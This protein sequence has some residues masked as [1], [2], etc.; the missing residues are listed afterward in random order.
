MVRVRGEAPSRGRTVKPGEVQDLFRSGVDAVVQITESFE[1]PDWDKPVCGRWSAQ[2]TAQHVLA[3]AGWYHQWLDRAVAD[4]LDPPFLAAE[5]AEQNEVALSQYTDLPGPEAVTRFSD[6]ATAYLAR[7]EAEWDRQFSYPYGTVTVG[8]H[9]GVA[10]TEMA[11]PRVG[12]VVGKRLPIRTRSPGPAVRCRR[13]VFRP[14]KGRGSW[15]RPSATHSARGETSTVGHASETLR[16]G[17]ESSARTRSPTS[18]S[19][20]AYEFVQFLEPTSQPDVKKLRGVRVRAV[21]RTDIAARRQ[22]FV[23]R[24]SSC[25]FSNRHRSPTSRICV[26][27][28]RVQFVCRAAI[29]DRR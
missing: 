25:S 13:V 21:S 20:V 27:Y 28:Q 7:T 24:T 6:R 1:D 26:V 4:E 5:M 23:W 14:G 2:Q 10:A 16:P 19:C 11:P 12:P 9:V 18:R 15:R 22:E 8:L 17:T 3:V 29:V